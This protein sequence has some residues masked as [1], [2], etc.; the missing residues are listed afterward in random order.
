MSFTPLFFNFILVFIYSIITGASINF[1]KLKYYYPFPS[2]PRPNIFWDFP[3]ETIHMNKKN[4]ETI[5]Y[6][7]HLDSFRE[8]L[9]M[10]IKS[11]QLGIVDEDS[12][13][14]FVL[15]KYIILCHVISINAFSVKFQLRC[16]EFMN[17]TLCHN[18]E[19]SFLHVVSDFD[20]LR[21]INTEDMIT[22]LGSDYSPVAENIELSGYHDC[23]IN[24]RQSFVSLTTDLKIPWMSYAIVYVFY[25]YKDEFSLSEKFDNPVPDINNN[26]EQNDYEDDIL[27]DKAFDQFEFGDSI[28]RVYNFL[29]VICREIYRCK[30]SLHLFFNDSH[31]IRFTNKFPLFQNTENNNNDENT[32]NNQIVNDNNNENNNEADDESISLYTND[33]SDYYSNYSTDNIENVHAFD[34]GFEHNINNDNIDNSHQFNN[35][36]ENDLNEEENN[37]LSEE[38]VKWLIKESAKKVCLYWYLASSLLTPEFNS[39]SEVRDFIEQTENEY[40][41]IDS[42]NEEF[43]KVLLSLGVKNASKKNDQSN[44][45]KSGND[46]YNL[47]DKNESIYHK[48]I[49]TCIKKKGEFYLLFINYVTTN[50]WTVFKLNREFVKSIWSSECQEVI[51]LNNTNGERYAKQEN[52]NFLHNLIIQIFR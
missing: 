45:N 17:R 22:F 40:I 50:E 19:L 33:E 16:A 25:K 39:R 15:D 26:D 2:P 9:H 28:Q 42:N 18:G 36:N 21:H 35:D 4:V 3:T 7:S 14:L 10:M 48:N 46:N 5:V 20:Y 47:N 30:D 23:L 43:K 29:N 44:K 6:R 41:I 52:N 49:M 34:N 37:N 1:I 8:N 13:F 12:F 38:K 11:G 27:D 51:G 32:N 24:V 31:S